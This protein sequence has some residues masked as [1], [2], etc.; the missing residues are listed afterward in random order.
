MNSNN[1]FGY[2]SKVSTGIWQERA[3][4]TNPYQADKAQIHGYDV[5]ALAQN[6]S[7]GDMIFL[8][9][10]GELPTKQQSQLLNLL[11]GLMVCQGPRD[12]ATRAAMVAGTGKANHEHILPIGL[13]VLG[14]EFN[15]SKEVENTVKFIRQSIHTPVKDMA[16]HLSD[17]DGDQHPFPG[18]GPS[19][20]DI[21]V[22]SNQYAQ[23]IQDTHLTSDGFDWCR[24]LVSKLTPHG[25]GWLN[26]G[27]AG[28]VLYDLCF[29]ARESG[30]IYQLMCAPGILAHG[31]EQTHKPISAMPL[32]E[33]E[34]YV[35]KK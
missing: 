34:N 10:K 27:L 2:A 21:N 23:V 6:K 11:M 30:G 1:K 32:L 29:G 19:Y 3:S 25:F 17:T 31:L 33:D 22:L 28:A 14:G 18:F 16:I 7:F 15:G 12:N 20:G 8:L 24:R 13:Q 4:S 26:T 9:F 35:L 5:T